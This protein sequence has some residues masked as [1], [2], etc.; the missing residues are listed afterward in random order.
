MKVVEICCFN[1]YYVDVKVELDIVV[2]FVLWVVF[3]YGVEFVGS[4]GYDFGEGFLVF[5]VGVFV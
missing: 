3:G 2:L 5:I 1:W 4:C